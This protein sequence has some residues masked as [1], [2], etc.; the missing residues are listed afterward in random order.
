MG[1]KI[2][3]E[4]RSRLNSDV[5]IF[6]AIRTSVLAKRLASARPRLTKKAPCQGAFAP[7]AISH[8]GSWGEIRSGVCIPRLAPAFILAG[9]E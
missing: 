7:V 5:N 8:C 6:G 4:F 9:K 1:I 3:L 2:T